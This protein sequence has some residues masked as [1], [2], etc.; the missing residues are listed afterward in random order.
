MWLA[1]LCPDLLHAI[2]HANHRG[3]SEASSTSFDCRFVKE[4]KGHAATKCP[5]DGDIIGR[6]DGLTGQALEALAKHLDAGDQSTG[7]IVLDV[8]F[9]NVVVRFGKSVVRWLGTRT[10]QQGTNAS[11]GGGH[12]RALGE[13]AGKDFRLRVLRVH[14]PSIPEGE[15]HHLRDRPLQS[16]LLTLDRRGAFT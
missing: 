2:A 10:L 6:D 8:G 5:E 12:G 15:R 13:P 3:V 7:P 4:R 14:L 1:G 11:G 16:E 9:S